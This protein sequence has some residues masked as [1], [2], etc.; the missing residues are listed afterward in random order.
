MGRLLFGLFGFFPVMSSQFHHKQA[1]T[2]PYTCHAVIFQ[3]KP[4][5]SCGLQQRSKINPSCR[6]TSITL[7]T[8]HN[9]LC[10]LKVLMIYLARQGSQASSLFI[11]EN[12][13]LT[14]IIGNSWPPIIQKMCAAPAGT[15][16]LVSNIK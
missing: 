16:S 9:V 5:D 12:Q 7:G 1:I 2:Q 6:M 13:H 4:L 8:I 10:P 15:T 11:Y 14:M 3:W